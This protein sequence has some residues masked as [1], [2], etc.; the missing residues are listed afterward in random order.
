[1]QNESSSRREPV[2]PDFQFRYGRIFAA[3]QGINLSRAG[4]GIR[5]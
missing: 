4:L 5:F 2:I 1:M 3:D